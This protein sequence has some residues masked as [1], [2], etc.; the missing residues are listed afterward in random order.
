LQV[1]KSPAVF[2]ALL[3]GCALLAENSPNC[4]AAQADA[5]WRRVHHSQ[6]DAAAIERRVDALLSR[7]TLQEKLGQ[8]VE[9]DSQGSAA[10]TD[11]SVDDGALAANPE[12]NYSIDPMQLAATGRMG[13]MLN[14]V[15]VARVNA[16]QRTAVEKSRLH[17]PLL[18]GADVI[19]GYRT[20]YPIPLG[21]AATFDPALVRSLSRISASEATTAG[22]RWFYSP[23]V[24]I[25]RDARWG[26]TS[27]GAGEDAYL[28][29]AMARA[30]VEGYQGQRLSDP[31]SVAAC[32]KHFAA[33][34]AVEA[35]REYNSTD[36]SLSRLWQDY[37]PPYKAAIDAGSAT[38][39][40]A[41][42]AF[43][44]LPATANP[45]LLKTILHDKWHFSGFVVSDYTAIRELINHG[46][47]LNAADAAND[48][49]M[50]GVDVD[51][52]SHLYDSQIPRLVQEGKI[53]I[54]VID[55]AVRR[56]LR[57]KFELGLFEH[58][59][60]EGE[61]VKRAVP[62]HRSLVLKAAEES[63]V[64]LQ[65]RAIHNS[66]LLP[67]E[68]GEM[69][70]ALIGPLADDSAEMLGSPGDGR[71]LADVVT[72]RDALEA[73]LRG[74]GGHLIYT[75]GADISGTSEDGFPEALKAARQADVIVMALGESSSMTGEAASR[76]H[77]NL[78]GKQEQLLK[79]ISM[80][81]KPIVLLIFS[82]RPLVLTWAAEHIPAIMEVWFPGTEAGDAVANIIFGDVSPSGK[83]PMSFPYTVGQEPLYYNQF[84]SGRPP[85]KANLNIPPGE[86]SKF[87]SRYIDTPNAALFPFGWGLSYSKFGYSNIQVSHKVVPVARTLHNSNPVETVTATVTNL[88]DREATEV[89]QC[90]LRDLGTRLEQPVRSLK[91]FRRVD[92]MPGQ[93]MKVSFPLRADDL[94]FYNNTGREILEPS[95][96]TIWIGGSSL[97][98]AEAR[99]KVVQ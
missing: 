51:M 7:M 98:D 4:H 24:D 46:V 30:Y 91:G 33:Y 54:S 21:L 32:V 55:D 90:Y 57:V 2:I 49:M 9:Y 92:L 95:D 15:G 23:M 47:A 19:H 86:D 88:G 99:F 59:Y 81:G 1:F 6:R 71:K 44:G 41:F 85:Y 18:F 37:L 61:E 3:V 97:A 45:Y 16:F 48:A 38:V 42:T 74:M 25:S 22:I 93:S 82:G 69:T 11:M 10:L 58:P 17:I 76:A 87:L 26:R 66:P 50:A 34:G 40:S 62:A 20:I 43:D 39:M 89:V 67:L 56:V 65:N 72:V 53:P 14:V 13:S 35:G 64:L 75:K 80:T 27:E 63:F 84:P 94:S 60:A 8:L 79:A 5:M 78:P 83:L 31:D 36:M 28:G 96:Y 77:L 70:I 73:R 68:P 12:V 52:M 29:A